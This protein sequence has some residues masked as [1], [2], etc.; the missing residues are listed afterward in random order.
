MCHTVERYR[1]H[2]IMHTVAQ[3]MWIMGAK[4]ASFHEAKRPRYTVELQLPLSDKTHVWPMSIIV[5]ERTQR[6][7]SSSECVSWATSI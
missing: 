3:G 5:K 7:T 6:F 1:G 4:Y 2:R